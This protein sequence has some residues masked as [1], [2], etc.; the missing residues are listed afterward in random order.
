MNNE[1]MQQGELG[2]PLSAAIVE[3]DKNTLQMVRDAIAKKHVML[4][5][6]P[7]VQTM[8]TDRP[9]YYEG[10]IRVLDHTGRVIP[11]REFIEVAETTELGRALDCS[12]I[13]LGL[14][15]LYENKNLRLA[16]NMSARSIG[17]PR[18]KETLLSGLAKDE[19]IAERL[20]LEITE[21]SAM[22]MPDLVTVFM[23]ELQ[24]KGI[25]F[26]LD[27]FGS[28]YTAFRYLR[29]FYFDMVK[30]DGSFVRGISSSPD[31]QALTQALVSV[32]KHFDMYTVAEYVENEEDAQY[33]ASI[34]V[35]CMQGHYFG[36][37][38]VN[39]IWAVEQEQRRAG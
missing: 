29:D 34:G 20:I 23:N 11:A 28:G 14:Q 36:V 19:T 4:A 21:S 2:D 3:R 5:Y 24:A 33:L 10:L 27:D 9:A 6:Q 31:N 25:S 37:A 12:S 7:I 32:A 30:I 35:D 13:E 26:A 16:I 38:T 15:A 22:V 39:P 8:R 17:Y 18:W 1:L